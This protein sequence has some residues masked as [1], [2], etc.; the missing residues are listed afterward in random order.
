[1]SINDFRDLDIHGQGNWLE[2][3]LKDLTGEDIVFVDVDRDDNGENIFLYHIPNIETLDVDFILDHINSSGFNAEFD[4][5]DDM[6]IIY[7]YRS[8]PDDIFGEDS[9]DYLG[10]T[11]GTH[12]RARMVSESDEEEEE[13]SNG[14]FKVSFKIGDV[15]EEAQKLDTDD[16]EE[17]DQ[18]KFLIMPKLRRFYTKME[19]FLDDKEEIK[20]LDYLIDDLDDSKD[21]QEWDYNWDLF[22]DWADDNDVYVEVDP[23]KEIVSIES[24]D[25][26]V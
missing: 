21:A 10:E 26:L 20:N 13:D 16:P 18:F 2:Q 8:L 5:L 15:W 12:T 3:S 25:D 6:I 11:I 17:F 14:D 7:P 24:Q 4:E 22:Y 23:P 19:T 9:E 1:M